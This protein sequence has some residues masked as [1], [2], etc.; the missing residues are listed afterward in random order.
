MLVKFSANKEQFC[1]KN[2]SKLY[3]VA[4]LAGQLETEMYL[5]LKITL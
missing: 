3:R 2:L 4:E 1:F 5:L